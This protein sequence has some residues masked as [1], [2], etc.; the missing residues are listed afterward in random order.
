MYEAF[1]PVRLRP[2]VGIFDGALSC[3]RVSKAR[4]AW[5][6]TTGGPDAAAHGATEARSHLP[7]QGILYEFTIKIIDQRTKNQRGGSEPGP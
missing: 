3:P 1:A 5:P 7:T 2:L 6:Q 4:S